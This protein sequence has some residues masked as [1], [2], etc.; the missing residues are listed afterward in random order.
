M[1]TSWI[2]RLWYLNLANNEISSVGAKTL[3][4]KAETLLSGAEEQHSPISLQLI[5]LGG[6]NIERSFF[7]E[8]NCELISGEPFSF[9]GTAQQH[10]PELFSQQGVKQ[11]SVHVRSAQGHPEHSTDARFLVKMNQVVCSKLFLDCMEMFCNENQLAHHDRWLTIAFKSLASTSATHMRPTWR[12][13][14]CMI[15]S[16]C[17]Q[18]SLRA[19]GT[20]RWP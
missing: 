6:N 2:D 11:S 13:M 15:Y 9:Q 16:I 7:D 12:Q 5:W 1:V 20:T 10:V 4:N 3:W 19:S 18:I 17:W 14:L 8:C